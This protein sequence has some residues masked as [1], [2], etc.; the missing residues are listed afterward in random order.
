MTAPTLWALI[1]ASEPRTG[2]PAL[3]QHRP[4]PM[5]TASAIVKRP[6]RTIAQQL[7]AAL[8]WHRFTPGRTA[9]TQPVCRD[10][11]RADCRPCIEAIYADRAGRRS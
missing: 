5:P 1:A 10:H 8:F 2:D 3:D 9:W 7:D 4:V 6:A 11:G